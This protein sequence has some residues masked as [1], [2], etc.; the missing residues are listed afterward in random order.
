MQIKFLVS[1]GRTL[2]NFLEEFFFYSFHFCKEFCWMWLNLI[3]SRVEVETLLHFFVVFGDWV[4]RK[5]EEVIGK[6]KSLKHE[7]MVQNHYVITI[8]D[9][10]KFKLKS[11]QPN[12]SREFYGNV[13][14][15][16]CLLSGVRISQYMNLTKYE[17]RSRIYFLPFY[18]FLNETSKFDWTKSNDRIKLLSAT[19]SM[20]FSKISKCSTICLLLIIIFN[21]THWFI[22][23]LLKYSSLELLLFVRRKRRQPSR[24]NLIFDDKNH[25]QTDEIKVFLSSSLK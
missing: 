8:V 15:G 17:S 9:N 11:C 2:L 23:R 4:R 24:N 12:W 22:E 25:K 6:L 5:L 1:H 16:V 19:S 14:Q 3:L 21:P 13:K 20:Q 7:L 10:I 18:C